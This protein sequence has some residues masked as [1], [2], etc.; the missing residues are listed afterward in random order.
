MMVVLRTQQIT[1]DLPTIGADP[2]INVVVQR[3]E[4]DD[5]FVPKN[6]I[7]RWG[8]FN[9][10]VPKVL[11]KVYPLIDSLAPDG[12]I[13][14]LGIINSMYAAIIDMIIERYGGAYDAT[15]GYIILKE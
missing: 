12:T 10:C 3:L 14:V 2:W 15:S 8:Q 5:N 6:T 11:G 7:D 4:V 9:V 1:V 13:S